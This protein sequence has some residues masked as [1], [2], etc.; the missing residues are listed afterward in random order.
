MQKKYIGIISFI[1]FVIFVT[2]LIPAANAAEELLFFNKVSEREARKSY[3]DAVALN[4]KNAIEKALEKYEDAVASY[5]VL[6][7]EPDYGLKNQLLKKYESLSRK[8]SEVQA[9]Y[10]YAY[11]CD[12]TGDIDSALKNYEKAK[13]L[14][15]DPV[16]LKNLT[17]R[18][19][20]LYNEK[21]Y[22]NDQTFIK[23]ISA[24]T[25]KSS[26]AYDEPE[27]AEKNNENKPDDFLD[28]EH[29][30]KTDNEKNIEMQKTQLKEEIEK[31]DKKIEEAEKNTADL[32]NEAHRAKN[33]WSGRTEY[34]RTWRD[35]TDS[36]NGQDKSDPYQNT[37]RRRYRQAK[38]DADKAAKNLESLQNK[39]KEFEKQLNNLGTETL[40]SE[41]MQ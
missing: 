30:K 3:L 39:K 13:D 31:I 33:D 19:K 34:R 22:E 11:L 5:S 12:L 23:N 6:I 37:Y 8:T 17:A 24:A 14:T 27:A 29:K 25:E 26:A 21:N 35:N 40:N 28:E 20:T 4:G 36:L 10:K 32:K 7:I 1:Y 41:E 9:F 18:L 16:V 15:T 38:A 2:S